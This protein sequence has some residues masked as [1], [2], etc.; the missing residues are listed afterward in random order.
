[1]KQKY[2]ATMAYQEKKNHKEFYFWAFA[3]ANKVSHLKE[4]F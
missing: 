3:E 1:L 2:D 4:V